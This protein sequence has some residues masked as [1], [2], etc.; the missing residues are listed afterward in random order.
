MIAGFAWPDIAI[1][2][3]IGLTTFKGFARGFVKE[4]GGLVA[5]IAALIAPWYYNGSADAAI[6][7]ATKFAAGPAHVVGMALTGIFAYV[8]VIVIASILNRIAKLPVLGTINAIAGAIV[9]FVK[10]AVFLWVVLFLALFFP[11]TPQIRTTLHQSHL[12]P[13]LAQFNGFVDVA[14]AN[15]VPSFARPYL[16]PFLS[17]HHF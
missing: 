5:L 12:V 2:I 16:L 4:L 13:L 15:S 14:I 9:G 8:I 17:G 3:L 10:G 11:L 6:E 7:S 1:V